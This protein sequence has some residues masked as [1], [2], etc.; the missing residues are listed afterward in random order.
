MTS[1]C[2]DSDLI[3]LGDPVG[4][5]ASEDEVAI[6]S[7]N[8]LE[9]ASDGTYRFFARIEGDP[10]VQCFN[11]TYV[12]DTT[13]PRVVANTFSRRRSL[14]NDDTVRGSKTWAWACAD[15]N[16]GSCTYR[17][18]ADRTALTGTTCPSHTFASNEE[19]SNF[20]TATQGIGLNS[21]N[22]KYCVHIQARDDA[23]NESEVVSVYATLDNTSPTISSVSVPSGPTPEEIGWISL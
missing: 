5:N 2:T 15:R 13:A 6:N 23:G 22:G 10:G 4:V 11:L 9:N 8:I 3:P 17:F 16:G 18:K 12:L 14:E 19:Y 7:G 20:S 1:R 21:T